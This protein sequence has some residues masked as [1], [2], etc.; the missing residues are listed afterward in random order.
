MRW[1]PLRTLCIAFLTSSGQPAWH[2]SA[3][4]VTIGLSSMAA[5]WLWSRL[6][7][8]LLHARAFTILVG[9]SAAGTAIPL[10]FESFPAAIASAVVFGAVFFAVVAATTDFIRRNVET[11]N[12]S[13]IGTF[14][15][16]FGTGQTIGPLAIGHIIDAYASLTAGLATGCVIIC[17]GSIL[18]LLQRDGASI[19]VDMLTKTS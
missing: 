18:G 14:T 16:A 12:I 11:D 10:V 8:R 9:V 4:W 7:A 17:L 13:A 15:V 1:S 2:I 5:P 3:F 19:E 6:F